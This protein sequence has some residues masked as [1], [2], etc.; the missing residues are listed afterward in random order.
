MDPGNKSQL[1]NRKLG[2]V[3]CMQE[4][5]EK[6][7]SEFTCLKKEQIVFL[8]EAYVRLCL[9]LQTFLLAAFLKNWQVF[10]FEEAFGTG[11]CG[12]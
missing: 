8:I 3:S 5:V 1:L 10:F 11:C 2:G 7:C 12:L 9:I 6:F 4:I